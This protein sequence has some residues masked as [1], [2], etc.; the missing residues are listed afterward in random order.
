MSSFLDEL[1]RRVLVFDGAM[2][3]SLQERNLT[4]EDFDGLEGC[5]EI[6]VRTRPDV[7]QDLHAAF[8]DVGVDAVETDSFGGAPWVLDEYDLG[9]DTE[10]LNRLSAEVA[11]R[12]CDEASGQR[13]VS[14]SIGPGTRSPT[15]SLT[16]GP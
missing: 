8:L 3:V 12:A 11:R 6:L 14:G 7:L 9:E 1:A 4:L 15:L 16:K 2:G 13:W 10:E 5:N